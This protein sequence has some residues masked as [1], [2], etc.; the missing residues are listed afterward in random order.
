MLSIKILNRKDIGRAASYYSAGADDYYQK[1]GE[2]ISWQ[3]KGADVLELKGEIDPKDLKNLLAGQV[4][5]DTRVSRGATRNDAKERIGIDLTF[6][7]PKSVSLQALVAGDVRVIQAHDR[8]V[9]ATIA[10]V[11]ESALARKR[12]EGKAQVERSANLIV[13]KFRHETSRECDPQLHTH[14]VVMNLTQRSDGAWRA[15]KNDEIVKSVKKFGAVYR[16]ELAVELQKIGFELRHE[17][18]GSFELAH[19]SREQ[20]E[21]FSQRSKQID[22]SLASMGLTREQANTDQIQQVVLKSRAKKKNVDREVLYKDWVERANDLGIDFLKREWSGKGKEFI[23]VQRRDFNDFTT[24]KKACFAVKYAIR[25][26]AE[27]QSVI[28]EKDLIDIAMKHG[29]GSVKLKDIE[30]EIDSRVKDGSL[31]REEALY[32]PASEASD[33]SRFTKTGW[34]DFL[35]EKGFDRKSASKKVENAIKEGGLIAIDKRYT[36]QTAYKLEKSIL[37]IERAGREKMT[38]IVDLE[39]ARNVLA[40]TSL[41]PGQREAAAL[42]ATTTNQVI[43]VQGYAG[44]GKSRMLDTAKALIEDHDYRVRALA[45]YG[46]QVKNLREM[47]IPANT[48]AAFLRGQNHDLNSRTVLVIDEAG[49]VP[50]R[51]MEQTL[52]LAEEKGARVVLLGDTAQTKAIE[53]GRPFDQLQ[54]AGMTTARMEHIQRQRDPDLLAAVEHAAGGRATQSLD[55]IK[56]VLEVREDALR[57][58]ALVRDYMALGPS[59][60]D[61]TLI[62]SGTNEARRDINARVREAVGTAGQG[63]LFDT[64]TRRDTTQAERLFAK[65]YRVG[66]VVQP[67][68]DYTCG[69]QRGELYRVED[70]GPGNR[71]T[72]SKDGHALAFSPMHVRRLSVYQPERSELA[73]GDMVRV[74][75]NDKML[76][77]A[78]GE[79][80]RVAAVAPGRVILE[81]GGRRVEMPT[82][83]PLHLDHAY[84]TTVHGAQGLTCDNVLIEAQ[85]DSRTTAKDV[86]YVA[87]S[88]AKYKANIYTNDL[89]KLPKSISRD[90]EKT[91]ALDLQQFEKKKDQHDK[92]IGVGLDKKSKELDRERQI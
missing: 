9:T 31:I 13:A 25:H 33:S 20:L 14:A 50:T 57:R 51:L 77:L 65:N 22:E 67:E 45:P 85:T 69:L 28:S 37:T 24:E 40:G 66:D 89:S 79:R 49:V 59:D 27:R 26:L 21:V 81:G 53:A 86:Y 30:F 7:A 2:S 18:E 55:K 82:D 34:V 32:K 84:A 3:G 39:T 1:E 48:L 54:A 80:Y 63:L 44:T 76:D 46:S 11:E 62:V 47:G 41:N 36:T 16:A 8:A 6:S 58:S 91:A 64:L 43:G 52:R 87:I 29:V 72:V 23:D 83:K 35:S 74:T 78:T 19:I 12:V 10:I 38:P 71:L 70:T 15:L 5:Y 73:P 90:N 56:A 68:K 61:N 42:M 4:A 17:R 92:Q 88:R 60:R 75:R